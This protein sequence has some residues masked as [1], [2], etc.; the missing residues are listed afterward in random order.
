MIK[1]KKVIP[2]DTAKSYHKSNLDK[3]RKDFQER[4]G[5]SSSGIQWLKIDNPSRG[6]AT[7]TTIRVLPPW[8]KAAD[9]FFYYETSQHFGVSI[10]GFNRA[11]PC[12]VPKGKGKC[13]VCKF[14]TALK[15]SGE[16]AHTKLADRLRANHR[17]FMN[18]IDRNDADKGVQVYGTSRKFIEA[19]IDASD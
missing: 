11:I 12:P 10:G 16:K 15:N 7:K 6:E 5:G 9:G 14:I 17:Y 4:G 19:V 2:I 8:G 13:P 1:K 18:V 3:I